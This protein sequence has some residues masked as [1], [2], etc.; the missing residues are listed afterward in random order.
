M[1]SP[2]NFDLIFI[3]NFQEVYRCISKV[4]SDFG[5]DRRTICKVH[6]NTGPQKLAFKL[7][8]FAAFTRGADD[9]LLNI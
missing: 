8:L 7:E 1:L 5:V 3:Q 4:C 2:T 6:M 9:I